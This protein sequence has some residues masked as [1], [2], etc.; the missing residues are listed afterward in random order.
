MSGHDDLILELKDRIDMVPSMARSDYLLDTIAKALLHLLEA[1][2]PAISLGKDGNRPSLEEVV[3]KI[4]EQSPIFTIKDS[5]SDPL[6]VEIPFG[7]LA[8][9]ARALSGLLRYSE[10]EY[11]RKW[12]RKTIADPAPMVQARKAMKILGGIIDD[13]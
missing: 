10:K 8:I 13:G 3:R 12:V 6:A 1:S 7:D 2:K 5:T 11:A 4:S 9:V